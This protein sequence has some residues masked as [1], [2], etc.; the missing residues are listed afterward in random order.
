MANFMNYLMAALMAAAKEDYSEE[1][2]EQQVMVTLVI[3]RHLFI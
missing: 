2:S 1:Y 3:F